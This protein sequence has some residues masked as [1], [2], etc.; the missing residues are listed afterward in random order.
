VTDI[1]YCKY[2]KFWVKPSGYIPT[3][4][5]RECRRHAPIACDVAADYTAWPQTR[6]DDG[7]GDGEDK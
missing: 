6:P 1:T 2:C 4:G 7:C 5:R 3:G